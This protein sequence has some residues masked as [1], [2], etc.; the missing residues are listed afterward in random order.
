MVLMVK[1]GNK[2]YVADVHIDAFTRMGYVI[3]GV[4]PTPKAE[5]PTA[6]EKP[7][8]PRKPKAN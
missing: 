4:A 1:D 2:E 7:K 5:A 3:D 8:T 6:V